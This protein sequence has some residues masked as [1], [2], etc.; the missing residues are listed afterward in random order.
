MHV[1]ALSNSKGMKANASH[2]QRIGQ[3]TRMVS[4]SFTDIRVEQTTYR[5]SENHHQVEPGTIKDPH[6]NILRR[7]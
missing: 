1:F 5:E 2:P 3:T 4:I 7:T 6:R